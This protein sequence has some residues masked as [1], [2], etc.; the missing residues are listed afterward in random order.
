[1]DMEAESF[2]R[3]SSKALKHIFQIPEYQ[4]KTY[5]VTR[6]ERLAALRGIISAANAVATAASS[7][8]GQLDPPPADTVHHHYPPYPPLGPVSNASILP[9]AARQ[10]G[11]GA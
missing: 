4:R 10:F 6:D 7:V 1:M 5:G 8:L 2:L 3:A 11:V 9:T